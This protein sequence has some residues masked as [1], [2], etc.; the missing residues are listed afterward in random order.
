MAHFALK[1]Y[2]KTCLETLQR[3]LLR[4]RDEG[5]KVAF[6]ASDSR[7]T[8]KWRR[9]QEYATIPGWPE[10]EAFPYVCLRL[11]TGGGKTILAAHAVGVA[12]KKY[13]QAERAVVLWLAPSEPIVSQTIKALRDRYHPCRQALDEA[14]KSVFNFTVH[15]GLSR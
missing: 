8:D 1:D 4:A 7:P 12:T 6:N 15:P 11:P 14:F 10:S 5:A 9:R 2:Q 13:L 3:F